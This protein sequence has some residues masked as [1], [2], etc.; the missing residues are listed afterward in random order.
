[1]KLDYLSIVFEQARAVDVIEQLIHL[2]LWLFRKSEGRVKYKE[3]TKEYS[4]GS[5]TVYGDSKRT[6]KNP[7][8]L[9]CYLSLGGY[10]C[11]QLQLFLDTQKQS[12]SGFF[13]DC[14]ELFGKDGFH[15]TRLDIAIDDRN[16]VPYFTIQQI[17]RKCLKGEF[18]ARGKEI[19][20]VESGKSEDGMEEVDTGK[21][22]YIGSIKANIRYR[23]YD[24]D[25]EQA[26][27]WN[28]SV[29]EIGSWKRTEIQLRNETAHAFAMHLKDYQEGFAQLAFEFLR[30]NLRF[31]KADQNQRNRNRWKTCQ[32]WERFIGEAKQLTLSAERP[33]NGL[34]ETREWLECGG[35]LSAVK[36][37]RYLGD[38][39][40][41][42]D[43]EGI[44][45]ALQDV[46]Y[47]TELSKKAVNHL[48]HLGKIELIPEIY[49][50]TKKSSHME[51][52]S[53]YENS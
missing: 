16:E 33:S 36:L 34:Y 40:A 35:C 27:K 51:L 20:S 37:L 24:K 52:N 44:D 18:I 39:Q 19:Q 15:V 46:K 45:N 47:S 43:L 23:F 49:E 9:G 4:M 25:K 10:G 28:R 12:L 22:V 8:G 29:E 1:V 50:E 17:K 7:L 31:V 13:C 48:W 42:G 6:E 14:V 41:L 26:G 21:T 3:Y 2:P 32:F 5:F 53:E 30:E 11:S 38:H